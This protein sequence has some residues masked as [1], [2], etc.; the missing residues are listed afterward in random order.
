MAELLWELVDYTELTNYVRAYDQRPPQG[1]K[2]DPRW[3]FAQCGGGSG[4]SFG[5]VRAVYL[6]VD[7]RSVPCLGRPGHYDWPPGI[8][9]VSVE[10]CLPS[11]V[12]L[13]L[14]EG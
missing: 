5:L 9:S 7:G 8:S 10:G 11:P 2:H 4:W 13:A 1:G 12:R 6:M 3:M 14:S